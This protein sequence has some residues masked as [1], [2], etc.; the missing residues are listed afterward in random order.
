[1]VT[2]SATGN[3]YVCGRRPTGRGVGELGDVAV[4]VAGAGPV[5]TTTVA[6]GVFVGVAVPVGV[7][8]GADITVACG[9]RVGAVAAPEAPVAVGRVP[10][11][12]VGVV[13]A[14]GTGVRVGALVAVGTWV[15]VDVGPGTITVVRSPTTP[16]V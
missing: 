3:V 7:E 4:G 16:P 1:M 12:R 11:S 5:L 8:G 6:T 9:V 10:G 14:V 15:G 13:V 2:R